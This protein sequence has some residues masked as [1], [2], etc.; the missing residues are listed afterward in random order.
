M[1]R[2]KGWMHPQS[3]NWIGYHYGL[4]I[5]HYWFSFSFSAHEKLINQ[6]LPMVNHH[7]QPQQ[8]ACR[9]P[10]PCGMAEPNK[11]RALWTR[12]RC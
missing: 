4:F 10:R 9:E 1:C 3:S 8:P 11:P 6:P 2:K 7:Q 5:D 12:R